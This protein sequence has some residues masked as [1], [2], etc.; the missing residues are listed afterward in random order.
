MARTIKIVM[1][2]ITEG[3]D[4]AMREK[5]RPLA[6]AGQQTIEE[7]ATRIKQK[8]RSHIAQAGFSKRW[9]NALRADVYPK[10]KSSL[11]AAAL[12][13]HK[14]PYADVFETGATIR[15]KPRMWI[16]LDTTPKKIGRERM[17]VEAFRQNIGPLKLL[18][19]AG[20]KPLLAAEMSATKAQ[21]RRG[22]FGKVT[23]DRL[24]KGAGKI[25]TRTQGR[26]LV[27]L[28]V[29]V[30][31]VTLRKRF[32]LTEVIEREADQIEAIFVEKVAAKD[33]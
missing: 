8:G 21:I 10:R 30:D 13:Y 16:P 19:R 7:I 3:F 31:S 15:G 22:F 18:N 1:K 5:Y 24:R 23:L 25:E 26:M 11:N 4:A 6:E 17:S 33:L 28:F 32:S 29:G 12:V 20:K 2:Q 14:I 9:Q 27:P